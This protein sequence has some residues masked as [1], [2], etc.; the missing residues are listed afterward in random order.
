ML[1]FSLTYC[2]K[3]SAITFT[4]YLPDAR[5]FT[6]YKPS[7]LVV[8]VSDWLAGVIT[9]TVAPHTADADGSVTCPRRIPVPVCARVLLASARTNV[10]IAT[11]RNRCAI[12]F[13]LL[14]N[15]P[16]VKC[17]YLGPP[18]R[19]STALTETPRRKNHRLAAF[20]RRG[21]NW[22]HTTK[23]CYCSHFSG[24]RALRRYNHD[25]VT[26]L[27]IL[28]GRCGHVT[29]NLLQVRRPAPCA[30]TRLA[31]GKTGRTAPLLC[32]LRR[33]CRRRLGTMAISCS[34]VCRP[35]LGR[36]LCGPLSLLRTGRGAQ[37]RIR[38][39]IAPRHV[40]GCAFES[41]R[42]ALAHLRR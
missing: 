39:R 28:E 18:R 40:T 9:K 17:N 1:T 42:K 26:F 35:T 41:H 12:V 15:M 27:H 30:V 21:Q 6:S 7:R 4:V 32:L 34:R 11:I 3:P 22:L 29:Q 8:V 2:A 10:R 31:V 36:K 5:P 37:F 24:S 33:R 20:W 19:L 25:R 23:N 16:P 14:R 38:A 13:S